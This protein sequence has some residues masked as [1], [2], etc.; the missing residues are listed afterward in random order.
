MKKFLENAV[1]LIIAAALFLGVYSYIKAD[2]EPTKDDDPITEEVTI[3]TFMVDCDS[4]IYTFYF[5]EGMTV[6]EFLDSEYNIADEK[7]SSDE[8]VYL[9]LEDGIIYLCCGDS[10][11]NMGVIDTLSVSSSLK[12][13]E[14]YIVAL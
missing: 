13:D 3:L 12:A 11:D 2:D 7:N 8:S 10:S 4:S 1:L 14:T 6:S 9:K 5:E